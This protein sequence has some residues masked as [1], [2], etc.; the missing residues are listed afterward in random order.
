MKSC[1]SA[2]SMAGP[3]SSAEGQ[4]EAQV[5]FQFGDQLGVAEE[6]D[7]LAQGEV[8]HGLA[9]PDLLFFLGHLAPFGRGHTAQEL[10]V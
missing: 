1:R 10:A 3:A 9:A 2:A 4:G 7:Y 6:A 8:T 5:A